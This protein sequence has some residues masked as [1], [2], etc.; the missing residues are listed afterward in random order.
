[1][2]H[3]FGGK[4]LAEINRKLCKD[5]EKKRG[6]SGG[7]R[8][9]LEDLRSAINHHAEDNLHDAVINVT[10]PEK[11]PSRQRY[12]TRHEAARFLWSCWRYREVQTVHRGPLKGQKIRTEKRPLRHIARFALIGLYTGTRAAAIA[13]ASPYRDKGR[14][15]V[16]LDRGVFFRLAQGTR[17]TKKR[18][19]PVPI[20]LRLLAH[21]RRWKKR[22]IIQSHFVEWNGAGVVS[23]KSG[24]RTA[25]KEAKLSLVEGN[26]TPHTLRHTAATWL[27]QQGTDIW[28]ASGFLGMSPQVLIDVYGH[29]HPDFMREAAN[30]ITKNDRNRNVSVVKTVVDLNH[31]HGML[32]KT[33]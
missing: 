31:R 32:K 23:V 10:L 12:L 3:F 26:V 19:P 30:A 11:G 20:P 16:D 7:A 4:M 24:F 29:H 14:S 28:Q 17:A 15:F 18:Q 2:N 9:D 1:L 25:V 6:N 22:G 33:P 27:M 21:M 5:Y 8:R 13:S